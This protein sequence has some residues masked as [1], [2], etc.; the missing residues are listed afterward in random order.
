MIYQIRNPMTN[1]LTYFDEATS[2]TAKADADA[3]LLQI[4][5][6]F[7]S[8]QSP[9]FA[10]NKVVVEG[11]NTTWMNADLEN[12][13]EDGEYQVLNHEVGT[14]QKCTSL[15]E[16]KAV[17]AQIQNAFLTLCGLDN[18]VELDKMPEVKTK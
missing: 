9:R 15:S 8:Y 17:N 11:N 13:P 7:L 6:D 5:H 4:R 18:P 1:E 14:Y 2:S 16:A 12:D 3:L 10:I